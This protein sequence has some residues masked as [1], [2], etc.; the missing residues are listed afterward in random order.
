MDRVE[1]GDLVRS[2]R[3]KRLGIAVRILKS[4]SIAVLEGVAPSVITT[5][6]SAK[7][8]E[9]VEKHSVPMYDE[10]L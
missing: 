10:T 4:G 8:L 1:L 3:S 2:T 5:H 9:I 7:T 6:D